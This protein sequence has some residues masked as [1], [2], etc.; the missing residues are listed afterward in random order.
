MTAAHS[1]ED[2]V[3]IFDTTLRDGEQSPGATMSLEEKLQIATLLDEMAPWYSPAGAPPVPDSTMRSHVERALDSAREHL[4]P[5][6]SLVAYG[7]GDWNDS[8]Q[9]ADPSMAETMTSAWTATLH[10]QSLPREKL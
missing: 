3:L 9:P 4:L 6:T 1:S 10:H 5:G 2:R 7:H 8:L